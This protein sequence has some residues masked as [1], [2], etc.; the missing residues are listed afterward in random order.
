M[1]SV[2][3]QGVLIGPSNKGAS[4]YIN[5]CLKIHIYK[6]CSSQNCSQWPYTNPNHPVNTLFLCIQFFV[7]SNAYFLRSSLSYVYWAAYQVHSYL[8]GCL[9]WPA[10]CGPR[11]VASRD[12]VSFTTTKI[13]LRI[14]GHC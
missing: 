10:L 12:L 8:D 1:C 3:D 5:S 4:I 14:W 13:W 11:N 7:I 6:K 2:A 9:I